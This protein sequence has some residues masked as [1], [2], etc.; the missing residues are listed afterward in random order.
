MSQQI[1][2]EWHQKVGHPAA[3]H[4]TNIDLE[5]ARFRAKLLIEEGVTEYLD[6]VKAG[7][8]VEI[9]DALGD[10]LWII[11][12]TAVAHG[13]DVEPIFDAIAKSNW[14]KFD[15]DGNPVP[16]PHIPGKIGKAPGYLPPTDDIRKEISRQIA[17]TKF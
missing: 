2:R 10:A 1:V 11:R 7:D 9:A 8:L 15:A 3:D 6:A 16:H 12:G 5:A 4:P 13:I 17:E 14:S